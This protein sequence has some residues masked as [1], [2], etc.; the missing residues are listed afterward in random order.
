MSRRAH[1]SARIRGDRF[2]G[3]RACTVDTGEVSVDL[4]SG[5]AMASQQVAVAGN[6]DSCVA[7][8]GICEPHVSAPPVWN[9]PGDLAVR[10]ERPQ[11]DVFTIR[12]REGGHPRVGRTEAYRRRACRPV[13]AS[14]MKRFASSPV[15]PCASWAK[16]EP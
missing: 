5:A 4:T 8:A 10:H 9:L 6:A 14:T 2:R 12:F 13:D 15:T 16:P 3:H 11:G 7:I 1:E